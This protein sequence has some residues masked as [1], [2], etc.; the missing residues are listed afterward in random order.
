MSASA[1]AKGTYAVAI[2]DG[3]GFKVPYLA[4]TREEETC[5]LKCDRCGVDEPVPEPRTIVD[6]RALRDPRPDSELDYI[7]L[8][9][10]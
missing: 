6:G 7:G 8:D 1:F 4:R 3:C 2:C 9:D 10:D 5:L